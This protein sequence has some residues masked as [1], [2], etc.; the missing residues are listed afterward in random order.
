[1]H[2]MET[3]DEEHWYIYQ[4]RTL[5]DHRDSTDGCSSSTIDVRR[6]G[7][8][9]RKGRMTLWFVGGFTRHPIDSKNGS[10]IVRL[11]QGR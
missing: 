5:P 3:H 8:E 4:L 6:S 7:G 9:R 11:I 10:D 1:M 2:D